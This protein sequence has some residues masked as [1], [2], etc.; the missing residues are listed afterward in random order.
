MKSKSKVSPAIFIATIL[1]FLFPFVSVSCGGQKV[2]S[3]SGLQLATGTTV[4]QPQM[5]GPPQ[6]QKV[7]PDPTAAVAA[8]CATLGV[9]LSLL[10]SR[11]AIAPAIAGA[12]GALSLLVMKSRMD[13]QVVNQGHGMLQVNYEA[14]Y[15]LALILFVAGAVWNGYLF[16][17]RT[18]VSGADPS[19]R[20]LGS[21]RPAT[22]EVM[23][24]PTPPTGHA[25]VACPSCG[26]PWSAGAKFCSN[27]GKAASGGLA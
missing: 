6:K 5:F 4:E 3:F 7:D 10:G 12:A 22:S 9:V 15:S 14:G 17:R 18:Q 19:I 24:H 8:L 2:A 21:D 1:C 13:N 26:E 27:C 20:Q 23:T 25:P 11:I 16:S